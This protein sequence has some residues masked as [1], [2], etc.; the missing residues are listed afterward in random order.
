METECERLHAI[1]DANDKA[2]RNAEKEAKTLESTNTKLNN[3]LAIAEKDNESLL[4]QMKQ[5]E[6]SMYK[7]QKTLEDIAYKT[8]VLK[9]KNRLL[10]S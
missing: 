5:R 1:L 6:N 4:E 7:T 3:T 2:Y 9:D 8:D 10:E